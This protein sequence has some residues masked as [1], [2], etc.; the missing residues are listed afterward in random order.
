MSQPVAKLVAS[1]NDALGA[2]NFKDA[3]NLFTQAIQADGKAAVAYEGRGCAHL[4]KPQPD[5]QAALADLTAYI[6]LTENQPEMQSQA[7]GGRGA[8][9][10]LK[11][12]LGAAL[13]DCSR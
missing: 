2:K 7:Y 6:Q 3:I 12:D 11:G 1:G 9:Y 10:R 5:Y 13:N 4:N 8:A